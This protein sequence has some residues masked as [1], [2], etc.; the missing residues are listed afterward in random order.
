MGYKSC[1]S[2]CS[3]LFP[4]FQKPLRTPYLPQ[5]LENVPPYAVRQGIRPISLFTSPP[6]LS[7]T[8]LLK[9]SQRVGRGVVA[10]SKQATDG[11]CSSARKTQD[12]S[13]VFDFA[14]PETKV[15]LHVI[16]V[17]ILRV[18]GEGLCKSELRPNSPCCF[19][20]YDEQVISDTTHIHGIVDGNVD[21][22]NLH[23]T[24]IGDAALPLSEITKCMY[25]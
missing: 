3:G 1:S 14:A 15:S 24:E 19:V 21:D 5:N 12:M 7:V 22:S 10:A 17:D 20:L 13:P 2:V 11:A 8:K 4:P 25:Q 9:R 16:L 6:G 18:C 23:L